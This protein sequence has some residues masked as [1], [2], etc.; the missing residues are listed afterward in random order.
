MNRIH[1][2][3]D[4]K[5][6]AKSGYMCA[7]EAGRK[8]MKIGNILNAFTVSVKVT[9]LLVCTLIVGCGEPLS[10]KTQALKN[11]KS[12][13][14][15]SLTL[16]QQQ[17]N[18]LGQSL[19]VKYQFLS[20][21][22]TDCP[23]LAGKKIEYCYGAEILLSN[24]TDA[25]L[26]INPQHWQLNYS[27]VYP[28]YASES[29]EF[30]LVHLNGD[31]H[32]ITPKQSFVGFKAGKTYRIKLWVKSTLIS[33]KE[34]MPNYW[35]SALGLKPV[36]VDS[37]KTMIDKETG[38]EIQPYVVPFSNT[39]K[40]IKSSPDDINQ[41]ASLK[42]LYENEP[43]TTREPSD[44][45]SA[46]L[47]KHA[48]I[49]TPK[50]VQIPQPSGELDLS[51]GVY[52]SLAGAINFSEIAAAIER[53]NF[54]G[55][56]HNENKQGV[57]ISIVIN[58]KKVSDWQQGHYQLVITHK[59]I[60]ILSQEPTGAF[61]ALQSL[62]S[63]LSLGS[64]KVPWLE[65]DDQPHYQYRGQHVDVARNFHSKAFIFSLIKQMAAYKLNKLHLHLAEDEGWR[66]ELPS[67]PELTQIGGS[68]C[69]SLDD[70]HCL[71]PQLGGAD[72]KER[73]GYYSVEDY[74]DIIKLAKAHHIQVIPSLDMPGHSRAAIKAMEARY[75]YYMSQENEV[76]AKRYL[77]TDFADKT[78]YSSIQ[79]YNDNTLN[80][81]ME[82]TYAF[83]DQVLDDL[84]TIH[85]KAGQPLEVYHI[86]ADE[87]AGAWVESPVCQALVANKEN[88]VD[89]FAHLGAHFIERVSHM[90]KDRGIVVAGWNDG[91]KETNPKNMPAQVYSYIWDALPWGAHKQV[92]EQA[93]RNWNIILSIP[94][95]LY[96]D[97]SYQIDPKERG[98]H[99]ASRRVTTRSL[100][101]FMPD[102][103]P[104]HAEFRVDTLGRAFSSNDT[105]QVNEG[106]QV[107]H[108]P[109]PK[110]Y[111]VSGIQGQLWS[112][113]VRSQQQAEYMIFPRLLALA[114]R[115]WHSADWA[116][117]Y[118][119]SGKIYDRT[120]QYFSS[121]LQ[122]ARDKQWLAFSQTIGKK[123]LAKLDKAKV[124]YRVPTPGAIWE[125]GQL[126][127]NIAL[128][129]L[130]I[131]YQESKGL[132]LSVEERVPLNKPLAIRAKTADKKRAGR[133]L[134]LP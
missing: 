16:S 122:Q 94:D 49:P 106:G 131:E 71:Q 124:F 129:G 48:I 123:E 9:V 105:K 69:M 70:K 26:K 119:Y 96:F 36:V 99:W 78:Q 81:C 92:S 66:L 64:S 19:Q 109:L 43:N 102:N 87:T 90:V 5:S 15:N 101:N 51:A 24:N 23:D 2:S 72:A 44:E 57:E 89:D 4:E 63:L 95:V 22:E 68:R 103:L 59:G 117:P 37:T 120:T 46:V 11:N 85:Q 10:T 62:S 31:I 6:H 38:L 114:E 86:G 61:Y 20:N 121:E 14:D 32:Q 8:L 55:I 30:S 77:L 35:L 126:K 33:E 50:S 118:D 110:H 18:N 47:V 74:I 27:Q 42:W 39:V 134:V 111:K 130:P 52:F 107:I 93:H 91:L 1:K 128:K 127:T 54:L 80:I 97:F 25:L 34:L 100:F 3:Q 28:V 88:T 12:E 60:Q 7:G 41:Y 53:L 79:N 82:S 45:K 75:R 76:E 133:A 13:T 116:V 84:Q 29:N 67:L 98:Y 17:L 113:T 21:V 83:I 115:A 73:D 132:W 108:K 104:I 40:Q 58:N 56:K 112:E 125:Q 65:I